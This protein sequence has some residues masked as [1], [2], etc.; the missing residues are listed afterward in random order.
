V[1]APLAP[2][3]LA[4][5]LALALGL[6]APRALAAQSHLLVVGGVG[7]EPRYTEEFHRWGAAMVDAARERYGLAPEQIVYLAERPERDPA[8]ISGAS[9]KENVER[10]LREMAA[11]AGPADRVLILL[12]GH[13]SSDARGARINLPG[14]DLSAAELA[15]LLEAFPTQPLVVVNAASASGD[16]QEPLAARNRAVVTA[17]RSGRERNET[18]FGRF[19]V[20]AFAEEG[21]DAD[22]DGRV[23]VL[24]A[25]EYATREVERSYRAGN[26]LQTEHARLEGDRELARG[27]H[28]AAAAAPI[29]ADAAPELRGL[30]EERRRLEE[31]VARLRAGSGEMEPAAYQAE[32]ERLLLELAR[33]SREIRE[34]GGGG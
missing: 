25:F 18:V 12:I 3:L 19:F 4:P 32:L 22:R 23:T 9:T 24:E 17:T 13:G 7:G 30:L 15:T 8:R 10:A 14:P 5:A 34:R 16:F 21:A 1:R 6:A 29:P 28:L 2:R 31:A 26:R 20:E 33:T 27:F 11:R